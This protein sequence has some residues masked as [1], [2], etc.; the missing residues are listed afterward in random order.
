MYNC[1]PTD[2][3]DDDDDITVGISNR[4]C[5]SDET[6]GT[7]NIT[8]DLSMESK[9]KREPIQPSKMTITT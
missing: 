6:V 9:D 3:D 5:P 1:L 4:S 7:E 2:N 8:D